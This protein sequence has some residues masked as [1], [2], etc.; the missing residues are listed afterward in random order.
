MRTLARSW[1]TYFL[2]SFI[3]PAGIAA[4]ST[5]P[6]QATSA[7]PVQTYKA[8]AEAV[9]VDVVVTDGKGRAIPGLVTDDF[10]VSEDG[11]PQQIKF[12]EEHG[13][14]SASSSLETSSP[15]AP[16]L[17]TN[18]VPADTEDALDILL[19][20]ALNTQTTDQLRVRQ[21]MVK[22]LHGI[23]RGTRIAVFTLGSNLKMVQGFTSDSSTLLAAL[24][25]NNKSLRPESSPLLESPQDRED[26]LKAQD[27]LLEESSPSLYKPTG[28]VAMATVALQQF[29][30]NQAN[31]AAETTDLRVRMTL[32]AF[33]QLGHFLENMPG[34]KNLIW[35]SGSFPIALFP[36]ADLKNPYDAVR[37][38]STEVKKTD[39]LLAASRVAVYPVDARGL[40]QTI[41]LSAMSS[42]GNMARTPDLAQKQESKDFSQ[43]AAENVTM[44]TIAN[45][46]GGEAIFNTN[47]IKDA[48]D[49]IHAR[50]KHFYT[51]MYSPSKSPK[52]GDYHRID[53]KLVHSKYKLEYRRGYVATAKTGQEENQTQQRFM[54]EMNPG[55]PNATEILFQVKADI[56][57]QTASG[58]VKGDN[59]K[60]KQ[61]ATRYS[62][63]YLADPHTL[64]LDQDSDGSLHGLLTIFTI[65]YDASGRA[66]N[67]TVASLKVG[68]PANAL[69]Q[70]Q[71]TG[72]RFQQELD[73]PTGEA[74][75]RSG[76]LETESRQMGS[77]EFRLR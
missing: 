6:A 20:D 73:V 65:A 2:I 36:D 72:I 64:R 48:L 28:L 34:R 54:S 29:Q 39:A 55:L 46:T 56:E 37:M 67:S 62:F 19:L 69:M 7:T 53:V 41:G 42:G 35:L 58:P 71:Q 32:T 49:E 44:T 5:L 66:L 25:A 77:L 12:F 51:L 3:V 10:I 52:D 61:P 75:V 21:Q 27:D 33:Q 38:Y 31:Y 15:P 68:V 63:T 70:F 26:R 43:N 30:Q 76:I 23:P 18:A 60:I 1:Q 13:R 57:A 50:G 74:I 45:E 22:Y 4:P 9:L 24:E 17:Y 47:D 8:T 14:Q 11:H 16:G 59:P 40:F